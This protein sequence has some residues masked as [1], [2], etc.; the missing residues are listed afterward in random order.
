[1]LQEKE[2]IIGVDSSCVELFSEF[3]KE[4]KDLVLQIGHKSFIGGNE[5]TEF[6]VTI[7]PH[8]LTALASYF[9]ARIQNS[10]TE[11]KI[12]KGDLEIELKNTDITPETALNILKQLEQ[13]QNCNE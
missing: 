9:V 6:I 2:I 8:L 12:K 5:I 4:H 11:I 7:T 13:G 1:M 10:K 3:A